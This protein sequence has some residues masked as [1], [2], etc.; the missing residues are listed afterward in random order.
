M[1]RQLLEEKG[2]A[3]DQVPCERSMSDLLNRL[4]FHPCKVVKNKPLRKLKETDDIFDQVHQINREAD[5][6]PGT[7][8]LSL[9]TKAVVAIGDLS[10]GGKS[11]QREQ[12]LDHDFAP[13][14]K[15]TPFG[16]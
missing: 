5:A 12:A 4:G 10:R 14:C 2:Y 11:R 15:L 8:R 13:E 16:L 1:R 6:D 3:P 9:D 7:V